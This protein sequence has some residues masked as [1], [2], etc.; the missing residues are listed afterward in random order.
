MIGMIG[1]RIIMQVLT[2]SESGAVPLP[3]L[4]IHSPMVSWRYRRTRSDAGW[5]GIVID[6]AVFGYSSTTTPSPLNCTVRSNLAFNNPPL[7]PVHHSGGAAAGGEQSWNIPT[8][9]ANLT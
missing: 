2:Q 9:D 8:G 6:N 1:A 5:L 4:P 7:V 3:V